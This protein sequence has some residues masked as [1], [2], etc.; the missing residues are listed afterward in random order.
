MFALR[1]LGLGS[2]SGTTLRSPGNGGVMGPGELSP[3][4][5]GVHHLALIT[6]DMDAT[7]RFWCGALGAR[8][9]ATVA[10]EGTNAFRHYFFEF[11][12]GSTIAFFEY[13]DADLD[14]FAQPAGLPAPGAPQ[15][16]PLAPALPAQAARLA[17]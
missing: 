9:V 11:G 6:P 8:L 15:L 7:V 5:R 14:F 13:R 3:R 12:A 4:W 1:S 17:P 16:A 10:T 2:A